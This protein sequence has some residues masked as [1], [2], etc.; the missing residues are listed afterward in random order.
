MQFLVFRTPKRGSS[1]GLAICTNSAVNSVKFI[2]ICLKFCTIANSKI[3]DPKNK[4]PVLF[5]IFH[6]KN[7][8]DSLYPGINLTPTTNICI[9]KTADRIKLVC[10][11]RLFLVRPLWQIIIDNK[12]NSNLTKKIFVPKMVLGP[13]LKFQNLNYCLMFVVSDFYD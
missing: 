3:F 13:K 4:N 2:L 10:F 6:K 9:S 1:F 7:T 11:L 8:R 12:F 5:P